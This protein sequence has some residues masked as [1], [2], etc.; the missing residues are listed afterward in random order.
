MAETRWQDIYLRLKENS[1]DVYSPGQHAGKCEAKYAVVKEAGA[2][3][4]AGISQQQALYD[5]MCYVPKN[6]YSTLGVYV[7]QIKTVMKS[8]K[9]MIMPMYMETTPFYDDSVEAWMVSIQYRNM[10]KI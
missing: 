2:S 10:K 3:Q 7:E 4:V 6:Q 8:L 1:I 9:P 5:I